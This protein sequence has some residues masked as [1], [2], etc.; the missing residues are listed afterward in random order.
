[1]T[2]TGHPRSMLDDWIHID[3][4]KLGFK[5]TF[6]IGTLVGIKET[7]SKIFFEL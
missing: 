4:L 3:I 1:M 2:A 7:V 6:Q 5:C